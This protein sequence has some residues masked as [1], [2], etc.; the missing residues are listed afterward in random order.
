MTPSILMLYGP[1][2]QHPWR[3]DMFLRP[4]MIQRD[5]NKMGFG[6]D[7]A[8][9][10]QLPGAD[11]TIPD[12]RIARN[13]RYDQSGT[14][15][16]AHFLPGSITDYP[17]VIDHWVHNF[18]NEILQPD[19]T[20]QRTAHGIGLPPDQVWNHKQ[21]QSYGNHKDKM[22]K[23][24]SEHGVGIRTYSVL[25]YEEYADTYGGT[26]PLLYKPQ[27][28]SLGLGIHVFSTVKDLEEAI[29]ANVVTRN[30]FIQPYL[31]NNGPIYDL[32]PATKEDAKLLQEFNIENGRPRE[33]RMHVIATTN[34]SGELSAEAY[35]MMKVSYPHRETLKYE[36][37]IGI[38]PS[39]L[40]PGT[41]IHDKSV[42]LAQQLCREAGSN[43]S[44]VSQF[45]G[46][47]DWL[48]SGSI[49]DPD[50]VW[51]VDGNCRGPGLPVCTIAARGAFER[52][53]V[54]S[55]HRVMNSRKS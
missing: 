32:T 27:G 8:V 28:G 1:Y 11:D 3:E 34:S 37:G 53:L 51:V 26:T 43:G 36:F 33:I 10:T 4:D 17:S 14:L 5:L 13:P 35:P 39:C 25:N 29:R 50:A 44:P 15:I 12:V 19:G 22:D 38:D 7:I 31:K 9:V 16:D 47:F 30:G 55:A 2:A 6:F 52:A 20:V 23:L 46:A 42:E 24:I 21:I 41:L 54:S 48:V 18:Q 49:Y 40:G 45:Y